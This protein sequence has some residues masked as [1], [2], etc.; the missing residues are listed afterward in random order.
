MTWA[1][2]KL[3]IRGLISDPRGVWFE[4]YQLDAW[5]R[6]VMN[7]AAE[8]SRYLVRQD[9]AIIV[10]GGNS[11]A[12]KS[13]CIQMQRVEDGH[14][15]KLRPITIKGLAEG[16]RNWR[17]QTG[18]ARFYYLDTLAGFDG[19]RTVGI[20]PET[21]STTTIRFFYDAYPESPADRAD[22]EALEIPKWAAHLVVFGVLSKCY[23]VDTPVRSAGLSGFYGALFDQLVDRLRVRADGRLPKTWVTGSP[24]HRALSLREIFPQNIPTP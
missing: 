11:F 21:T 19:T 1:D 3:L 20:Y 13:D 22:T 14:E 16:N 12:Q 18:T 8:R 24:S 10:G 15:G 4:D 7:V 2:A 5:G 9:I 23:D 17:D 6:T